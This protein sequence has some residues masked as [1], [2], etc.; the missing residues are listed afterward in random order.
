MT[1]KKARNVFLAIK[2]GLLLVAVFLLAQGVSDL[3]ATQS[4]IQCSTGG[5]CIQINQ[6]AVLIQ[7][8]NF[9]GT[10]RDAVLAG[11]ATVFALF[12]DVAEYSLGD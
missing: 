11:I 9:V 4:T 1:S 8:V 5:A 2:V 12:V 6:T 7:G 10:L 3:L